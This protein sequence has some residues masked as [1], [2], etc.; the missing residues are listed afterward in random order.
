MTFFDKNNPFLK[1]FNELSPDE[2]QRY[3]Q[4]GKDL[5][6]FIDFETGKLYEE[7][8]ESYLNIESIKRSLQSGLS[9]DDLTN[10]ERK[11]FEQYNNNHS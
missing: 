7:L 3:Q 2:Q 11:L 1:M 10:D 4:K 8:P 9:V 6:E 5:Y